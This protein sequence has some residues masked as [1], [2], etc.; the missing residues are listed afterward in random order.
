MPV[1][2]AICPGERGVVRFAGL[3]GLSTAIDC[4]DGCSS[5]MRDACYLLQVSSVHGQLP[6]FASDL[7]LPYL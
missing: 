4:H 7:S 5:P 3:A 2:T 6:Y 1:N